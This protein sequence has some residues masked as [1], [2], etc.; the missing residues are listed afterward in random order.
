MGGV[1]R[2]GNGIFVVIAGLARWSFTTPDKE[3]QVG[4][5]RLHADMTRPAAGI[6]CCMNRGGPL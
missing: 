4:R 5:M 6:L 3:R 2:A 1:P